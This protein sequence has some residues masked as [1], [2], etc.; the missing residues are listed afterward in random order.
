MS[1]EEFDAVQEMLK[2]HPKPR[3]AGRMYLLSGLVRC[4][5]CGGA[6]VGSTRSKKG[7]RVRF[8]T[9]SRYRHQGKTGCRGLS[10]N[11]TRLEQD[12]VE[13]LLKLSKNVEFLD[14]TQD[15]IEDIKM[16]IADTDTEAEIQRIDSRIQEL[17]QQIT[18]LL[19]MKSATIHEKL[20]VIDQELVALET[21]KATVLNQNERQNVTLSNV[22]RAFEEMLRFEE[23]WYDLSD[24]GKQQ[25][26]QAVIERVVATK[27]GAKIRLIVKEGQDL[28]FLSYQ[29]SKVLNPPLTGS[30]NVAQRQ[31]VESG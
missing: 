16:L 25:R 9:C 12:I 26:L 30:T 31:D 24:E 23:G 14:D 7:N 18:V 10:L 17:Q 11:A 22:Q 4:G 5:Y 2:Q 27:E 3:R 6:V 20:Q 28:S 1:Q 19:H 8:Y 29:C 15:L 21:R 13:Y